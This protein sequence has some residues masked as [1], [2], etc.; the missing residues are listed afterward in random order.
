MV[1]VSAPVNV[2]FGMDHCYFAV[3]LLPVFGASLG[4][5]PHWNFANTFGV[6]KLR[7]PGLFVRHC[8]RHAGF[9]RFDNNSSLW[10]TDKTQDHSIASVVSRGKNY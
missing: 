1:N 5:D 3:N 2:K 7:V 6:R 4:S 9:S 10:R 8:L